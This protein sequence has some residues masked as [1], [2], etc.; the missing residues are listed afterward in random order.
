MGRLVT[1]ALALCDLY[2]L[3]LMLTDPGTSAVR[4]GEMAMAFFVLA[5]LAWVSALADALIATVVGFGSWRWTIAL[6]ALIWIPAL[7]P[8]AWA[9]SRTL[10][11]GPRPRSGKR[12]VRKPAFAADR[13]ESPAEVGVA[14]GSKAHV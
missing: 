4:H 9:I 6:I 11:R 12:H 7:P 2:V 8:L 1:V 13:V 14:A 5:A 3:W 10:T